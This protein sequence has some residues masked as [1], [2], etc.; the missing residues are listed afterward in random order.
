MPP[1]PG[2]PVSPAGNMLPRCLASID[3]GGHEY[4]LLILCHPCSSWAKR[5]KGHTYARAGT[6]A[7][8][9]MPRPHCISLITKGQKA[10]PNTR[11]AAAANWLESLACL[12][13]AV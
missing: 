8:A 3:A 5:P 1:R 10:L 11:P 6:S 7:S 4:N 9:S 13:K 12:P 2:G